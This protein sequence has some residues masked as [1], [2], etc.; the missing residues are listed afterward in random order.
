MGEKSRNLLVCFSLTYAKPNT[1]RHKQNIVKKVTHVLNDKDLKK[2][3]FFIKSFAKKKH[4]DTKRFG[5][6]WFLQTI[7]KMLKFFVLELK[8]LTFC[9]TFAKKRSQKYTFFG[10]ISVLENHM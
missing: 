1:K 9:S 5:S 2:K 4:S 10:N 7:S 3:V 6:M 8:H